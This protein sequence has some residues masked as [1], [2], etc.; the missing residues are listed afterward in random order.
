[1]FLCAIFAN[2]SMSSTDI[3]GFAIVS[4]KTTLV[5]SLNSFCISSSEDSGL[6]NVHSIPNL[7]NVT[8]NKLIV[9]PGLFFF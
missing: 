8:A 3:D 7:F 1:M 6:T 9:P 2:F 5:F 4:P